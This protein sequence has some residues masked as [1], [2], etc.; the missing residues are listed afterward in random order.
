MAQRYLGLRMR[1]LLSA[2]A[3]EPNRGSESEV[4]WRWALELAA[5]GDDV[6]VI[7]RSNNR[8][9]IETQICAKRSNLHFVYYDLPLSIRKLKKGRRFLYPYAIAWQ[10]GAYKVARKLHRAVRF[11]CVRHVTFA[12]LRIPGFMGRLGIPYIIG[13]V[14]GGERAP[15]RLRRDY[16]LKGKIR[17]FL[18]DVAAASIHVDPLVRANLKSA[19]RIYVTSEESLQLIPRKY[20]AKTQ[21]RLAIGIESVVSPLAIKSD[22][23]RNPPRLLYAGALIYLKGLHLTLQVLAL[24]QHK[25]PGT[26]LTLI[27]DGPDKSWLQNIVRELS[28]EAY[29]RWLAPVD[30]EQLLGMYC[31]YDLF[32]FPSL[33]DSGGL[34][35]LESLSRGLP[36]VCLNLGGP[37]VLVDSSC[38]R[39]T[40]A[41]ASQQEVVRRLAGAVSDIAAL[42][43]SSMRQLRTGALERARQHSWEHIVA[44]S[45]HREPH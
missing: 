39:V 20:R 5:G 41:H 35:V 3:C 6:W 21:V 14:A 1:V 38:G 32:L 22:R 26:S 8:E 13:P 2:Y 18:R 31:D 43:A 12:S 27:G 25:V 34:V 45:S 10:W 28:L 9:K 19:Q 11:D 40:D 29:V 4:G 44:E 23:L 37:G 15:W 42:S 7:T 33:H 16:P 36:V 24:L 17:D 30:R